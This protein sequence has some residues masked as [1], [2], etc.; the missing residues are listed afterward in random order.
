MEGRLGARV[1]SWN[2]ILSEMEPSRVC[3]GSDKVWL[4]FVALSLA[5]HG[6]WIAGQS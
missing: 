4:C 2:F 3:V 6:E 1:W 5:A